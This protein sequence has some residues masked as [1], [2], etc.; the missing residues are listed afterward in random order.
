MSSAWSYVGNGREVKVSKIAK[1]TTR[2]QL[3]H[4]AI[5]LPFFNI[6]PY[7]LPLTTMTLIAGPAIDSRPVTTRTLRTGPV[8]LSPVLATS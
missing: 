7:R 3:G 6:L 4:M 2:R 8:I 5:V 1:L